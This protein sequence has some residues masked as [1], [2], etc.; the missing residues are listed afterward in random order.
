MYTIHS[1]SK[2]IEHL[3]EEYQ[4]GHML[5][6][7]VTITG[8]LEDDCLGEDFLRVQSWGKEY[9]IKYSDFVNYNSKSMSHIGYLLFVNN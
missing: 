7:Y 8:V 3:F 1:E 9:Y 4:Y 6:H 5:S 2:S